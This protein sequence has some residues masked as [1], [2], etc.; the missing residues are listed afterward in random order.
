MKS[1]YSEIGM[2]FACAAQTEKGAP[3]FW[4]AT[5]N[6]GWDQ[7]WPMIYHKWWETSRYGWK[8]VGAPANS[9]IYEC[10]DIEEIEPLE[11]TMII[12]PAILLEKKKA[13]ELE[14]DR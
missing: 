9:L 5:C 2:P 10:S 1:Y 7:Q 12:H 3:T 13:I 6:N 8:D 4:I 14:S 11:S